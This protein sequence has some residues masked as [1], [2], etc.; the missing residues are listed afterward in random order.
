MAAEK[1]FILLEEWTKC[2]SHSVFW[3]GHLWLHLSSL[4]L[5]PSFPSTSGPRRW[6][7]LL[8]GLC[9]CSPQS[10]SK[11]FWAKATLW[12]VNS[13][14]YELLW[15][16]NA[17][18]IWNDS[19][20]LI[21]QAAHTVTV[22]TCFMQALLR[23]FH[24]KYLQPYYPHKVHHRSSPPTKWEPQLSCCFPHILWFS[25]HIVSSTVNPFRSHPSHDA[26]K[27]AGLSSS[28]RNCLGCGQSLT[29]KIKQKATFF[30][31]LEL[32][33]EQS[34]AEEMHVFSHP[35]LSPVHSYQ[36]ASVSYLKSDPWTHSSYPIGL[37]LYALLSLPE[38]RMCLYQQLPYSPSL[39]CDG[40][41][42]SQTLPSKQSP[43]EEKYV[44]L[45]SDNSKHP[46]E[47]NNKKN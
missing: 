35:V 33:R 42:W 47:L 15:S 6:H 34:Y 40:C 41:W 30:L 20:K 25:P 27:R 19:Q 36:W 23:V 28:S 32:K 16:H 9:S 29:A 43:H 12:A 1:H 4:W 2:F 8:A 10:L 39:L 5:P 31:H 21:L 38:K 45:L 22:G 3:S 46:L 7:V 26:D 24:A 13:N 37:L 44:H 17:G 14:R 18:S 11:C